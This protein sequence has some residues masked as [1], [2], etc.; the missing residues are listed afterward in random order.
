MKSITQCK[1]ENTLFIPIFD[2]RKRRVISSDEEDGNVSPSKLSGSKQQT[3]IKKIK[4]EESKLAS[5]QPQ[6][7]LSLLKSEP[8]DNGTDHA[9]VQ[10]EHKKSIFQEKNIAGIDKI[11]YV[12]FL[13]CDISR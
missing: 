6:K 5:P 7:D 11:F 8:N 1:F 3:A 4:E 2:R 10:A 12:N 9:L 13:I